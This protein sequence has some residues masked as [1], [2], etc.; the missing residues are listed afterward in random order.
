[1]LASWMGGEL[2]EPG[3]R[4]LDQA[5]IATFAYPDTA[6]HTFTAMWRSYYNLQALYETPTL[7]TRWRER[8]VGPQA[9]PGVDRGCT[10][11]G[12]DDSY[13]SRIKADPGRLWHPDRGNSHVATTEDEAVSASR[14]I[15][16]PVVLKLHSKTITHKTDVGGV[17]LDLTER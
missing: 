8:P 1:M 4:I 17:Q 2:V 11:R 16:F 9:D 5:G 15:G 6:A 12:T 7:P 14:S 13:R 3:E 10:G